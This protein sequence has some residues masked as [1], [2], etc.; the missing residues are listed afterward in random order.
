MQ[1]SYLAGDKWGAIGAVPD[2]L[3]D[4][5]ARCGPRARIADRLALWRNG[6]A[7]TLN[8]GDPTLATVRMM[9][10]LVL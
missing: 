6:A 7:T 8:I 9:A 10:E 3:V 5:V 1:D 4:A 2:A